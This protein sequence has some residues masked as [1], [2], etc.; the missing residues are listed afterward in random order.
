ME[1]NSDTLQYTHAVI[2]LW[3]NYDISR[4]ESK[5]EVSIHVNMEGISKVYSSKSNVRN[6]VF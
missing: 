6:M 4:G 5:V 2:N 3:L 1:L